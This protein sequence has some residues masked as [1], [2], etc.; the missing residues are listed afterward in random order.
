[1]LTIWSDTLRRSTD[2]R[3]GR[4]QRGQVVV[5]FALVLF[6]LV[7]A[8][9]GFYQALHFELD[10]FNRINLLRYNVMRKA[11]NDQPGTT[12]AFPSESMTFRTVDQLL[13]FE[14]PLQIVDPTLAYGPKRFVY[15]QGTKYADPLSYFHG[16]LTIGGLLLIGDFNQDGRRLR[17]NMDPVLRASIV[18]YPDFNDQ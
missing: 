5:E 16:S 8:I 13:P 9:A 11:H 3:S 12:K 7:A 1:M 18:A 6:I 15:R 10:V 14:V 4:A 2:C 17:E